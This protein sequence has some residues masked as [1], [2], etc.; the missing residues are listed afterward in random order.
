MDDLREFSHPDGI[1]P[2]VLW[3]DEA[4]ASFGCRVCDRA[5]AAARGVQFAD[6]GCDDRGRGRGVDAAS[7][8]DDDVASGMRVEC[9][10]RRETIDCTRGASR[11]QDAVEAERDR[12]I[13]RRDR[14]GDEVERAVQR[15]LQRRTPRFP[16]SARECDP[17]REHRRVERALFGARADHHARQTCVG[18]GADVVRDQRL[19][20]GVVHEP[21]CAWPREQMHRQRRGRCRTDQRCRRGQP[22]DRQRRA[23]FDPV[24]AALDG[25]AQPGDRLDADF[26]RGPIA[27][28]DIRGCGQALNNDAPL[29]TTVRPVVS[30]T[31]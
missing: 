29:W 4:E 7:G 25:R 18:S 16:K 27:A 11:G 1:G 2:A 6:A 14:I 22:A 23:Q 24:R 31:A 19:L 15:Q 8:E 30:V 10:K 5:D 9:R 13:Q 28:S 21:A 12:R 3:S 17:A 26:Q 20:C